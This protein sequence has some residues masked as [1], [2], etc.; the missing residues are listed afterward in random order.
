MCL[1]KRKHDTVRVFAARFFCMDQ[2]HGSDLM[3]VS[4]VMNDVELN[5]PADKICG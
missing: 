3:L 4:I 5:I 2:Y 1:S